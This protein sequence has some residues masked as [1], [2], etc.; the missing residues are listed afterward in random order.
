MYALYTER[1]EINGK[2][3]LSWDVAR[4]IYM[5]ASR[6][7]VIVVTEKPVELLSATRR[8]WFKLMR[9]VM[10]QRS[11]TLS[12]TRS[13]ELTGQIGFMQNLQFSAKRP[14]E[15]L[16]ADITFA[17]VD[18]LIKVAPI[19]GT[20]YITHDISSEKLH[21]LTSWMPEGGVVVIYMRLQQMAIS[22]QGKDL[23]DGTNARTADTASDQRILRR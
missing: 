3:L 12:A 16:G 7:K 5:R 14:K 2:S 15:C 19:C 17:T 11:S 10:R 23:K 13:L 20:A 9:Y 1:R 4:H 8:Q 6:E 18:D 22:K 21:M